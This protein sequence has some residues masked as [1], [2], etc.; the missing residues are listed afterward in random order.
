MTRKLGVGSVA[1]DN[2]LGPHF[3]KNVD[4]VFELNLNQRLQKQ[5]GRHP[6]CDRSTNLY[7][8]L[9]KSINKWLKI[10]LIQRVNH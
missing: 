5:S 10:N 1:F 2:H 8:S 6:G 7:Y 4:T 3:A 9:G